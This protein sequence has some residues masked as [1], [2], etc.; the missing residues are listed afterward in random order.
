MRKPKFLAAAVLIAALLFALLYILCQPAGAGVNI[1]DK[2][3][4]ARRKLTLIIE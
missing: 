1:S 3:S 2:I 4:I